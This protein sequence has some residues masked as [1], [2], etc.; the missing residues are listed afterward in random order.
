MNESERQFWFVTGL[1]IV[2]VVFAFVAFSTFRYVQHRNAS[3]QNAYPTSFDENGQASFVF[4]V[5]SKELKCDSS[6][7]GE[8]KTVDGHT[9]TIKV[10]RN[11]GDNLFNHLTGGRIYDCTI[12]SDNEIV[13]CKKDEDR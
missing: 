2:V 11:Q 6:C 9:L 1:T 10:E 8:I 4:Q 3:E 7:V 13:K 12:N 5:Q